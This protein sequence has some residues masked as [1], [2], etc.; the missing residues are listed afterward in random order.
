M[1]LMSTYVQDDPQRSYMSTD[2]QDDPGCSWM[3]IGAQY[4]PGCRWMSWMSIYAPGHTST[5]L[6]A[7]LCTW[8][9][10]DVP[11]CSLMYLLSVRWKFRPLMYLDGI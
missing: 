1:S 9:H 8:M 2:A 6:V 7:P 4:D 10:L 11:G 3:S 5:N